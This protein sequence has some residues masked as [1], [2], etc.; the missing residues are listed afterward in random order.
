MESL[1]S[2]F[3]YPGPACSDNHLHCVVD[4]TTIP[5]TKNACSDSGEEKRLFKM[6]KPPAEPESG[7]VKT[8]ICYNQ[9]GVWEDTKGN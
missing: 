6:K 1:I 8:A 9:L 2:A 7:T 5:H 3:T 4:F